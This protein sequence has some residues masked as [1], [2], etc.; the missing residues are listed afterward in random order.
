VVSRNATAGAAVE[1]GGEPLVELG[2]PSE[3]W[4]VADVFE[5]DLPLI[6]EGARA[7]VELPTLSEPLAGRVASVGAVLDGNARTAPVRI[8]LDQPQTK[9]RPGMF[10]RARIESPEAALA[11]PT[12]AV[13]IKDGRQTIVYVQTGPGTYSRR[14]VVVAQ[15]VEGKVLVSSGISAGDPVVV[16]GAL[17]L[18]G[19]AEQL[20]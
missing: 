17:L 2:D 14:P 15:P 7:L 19:A 4:L 16:Q 13:L 8:A 12:E 9:L 10:G 6:R 1:P 11:L 18:D 3:L 5:R 20:L